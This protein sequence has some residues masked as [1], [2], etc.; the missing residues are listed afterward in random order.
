MS[1]REINV[2]IPLA[3]PLALDFESVLGM[4]LTGMEPC[5]PFSPAAIIC[6]VDAV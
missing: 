1:E 6:K 4:K 3:V 2:T 5:T